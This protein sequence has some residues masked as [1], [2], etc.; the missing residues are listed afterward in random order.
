MAVLSS[1]NT[2]IGRRAESWSNLTATVALVMPK[3]T[4]FGSALLSNTM[5]G[6]GCESS[7]PGT[8]PCGDPTGET[9]FAIASALQD[10][11]LVTDRAAGTVRVF[12]GIPADGPDAVFHKLRAEGG[13]MVSA[14]RQS[15]ATAFV[16]VRAPATAPSSLR[17]SPGLPAGFVVRCGRGCTS[18]APH[19]DGTVSLAF[20]APNAT[21]MLLPPGGGN[22]AVVSPVASDEAHENWWGSM[23]GRAGSGGY[24]ALLLSDS[25]RL[26]HG[27]FE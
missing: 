1:L 5:Y 7:A 25:I 10:T 8:I 14:R 23:D 21:A 4:P 27:V 19:S 22:G 17:V 6:E 24:T 18:G 9:P 26:P 15:G 20:A 13:F 12:A 2:L 16:H 3:R 11:L